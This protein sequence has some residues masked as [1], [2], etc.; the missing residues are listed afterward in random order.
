MMYA[1]KIKKALTPLERQL[2]SRLNTPQK[3]QD[4]L[5]SL[6]INFETSGETYMSPRRTIEAG[7]A[8]CFEGALLAA[9]I[10]AYHGQKP[11][12]LDLKTAP[13]DQDHVVALFKQNGY[14]G[15]ISKTNHAVLRYRDPIYKTVRELALSYFH[16]YFM[17]DGRK[18]LRTYSA[19][20]DLSYRPLTSWLTA[21]EE[22]FDL[23]QEL[24]GSPH[25]P[26]VP[27]E[28]LKLLR[29]AT[30]FEVDTVEAAEWLASGKKN[31]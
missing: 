8:H 13:I 29:R 21:E 27:K 11:L 20:F 26:L 9:A 1:D 4:Y 23:V 6:P 22:L 3:I 16:E 15:A 10:L 19:P 30:D 7:A 25:F 28:N 18:T 2:F 31:T 5:D 24:D 12:I 14:W 17:K